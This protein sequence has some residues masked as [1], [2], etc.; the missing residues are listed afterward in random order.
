MSSM[1]LRLNAEI[2]V[3]LFGFVLPN[4]RLSSGVVVV[5]AAPAAQ[6]AAILQ[7]L[8][9]T[10]PP[11]QVNVAGARRDSRCSRC[12]DRR[13][14]RGFRNGLSRERNN[15]LS[16]RNQENVAMRGWALQV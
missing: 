4:T 9:P 7:R 14:L 16:Q 3:P 11:I 15:D 5:G 2:T 10:A 8:P 1:V 13:L 6:L 12:N